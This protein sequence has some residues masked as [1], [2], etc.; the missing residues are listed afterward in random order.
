[1]SFIAGNII[2]VI[3]FFIVPFHVLTPMG[4][5][6]GLLVG[7][8]FIF[9]NFASGLRSFDNQLVFVTGCAMMLL[10]Y[11]PMLYD[12]FLTRN[13]PY[14]GSSGA[15]WLSL[16]TWPFAA[17]AFFSLYVFYFFLNYFSYAADQAA[18]N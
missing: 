17:V 15:M 14:S 16:L 8:F 2:Y 10:G 13:N 9:K 18:V 6:C 11:G 4:F 12:I 5:I 1:M 3:S 7:P